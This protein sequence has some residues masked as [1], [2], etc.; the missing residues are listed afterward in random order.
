[1]APIE[2]CGRVAWICTTCGTQHEPTTQPPSRCEICSD[3]RQY[4]AWSGQQWTSSEELREHHAIEFDTEAGVRTMRAEPSFGIGQRAFL[5]PH[6]PGHFMWEC[7]SPVT[8]AAVAELERMGGVTGIAIS[9]P[10]FYSSMVEWS[11]A[12]GNVPVYL[13]AADREW[14]QRSSDNLRFWEGERMELADNLVLVL[15]GGHFPGSAGLWWKDGPRAGG[16][17]FPGD[18]IQV[19]MDRRHASFMY[20]YPNAIPLAPSSVRRLEARV[21]DLAYE[22]VFGYSPGRQII[23]NAKADIEASFGRYLAAVGA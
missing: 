11:E 9:H 15:L 20:S 13:H 23:G 21:D 1:M 3:E 10:H 5:V 22:D 16:S 4:V 8:G 17:L 18:A 7:L 12:L 6:G 14:V 2:N 19:V